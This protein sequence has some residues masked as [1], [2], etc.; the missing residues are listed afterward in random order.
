MAY[1]RKAMLPV[2]YARPATRRRLFGPIRRVTY[3]RS[4]V[5]TVRGAF[6]KRVKAV[7]NTTLEKKFFYKIADVGPFSIA[8]TITAICDVAQGIT[9]VTRIGEKIRCSSIELN[10]PYINGTAFTTWVRTTVLKVT[11]T[12]L[13]NLTSASKIYINQLTNDQDTS[14]GVGLA[15]GNYQLFM[16]KFDPAAVTV[17]WDNYMKLAKNTETSGASVRMCQKYVSLKN[18][19]IDF[20]GATGGSLLQHPRYFLLQTSYTPEVGS[21]S[22]LINKGWTKLRFTDA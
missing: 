14:G 18:T 12:E 2:R 20:D 19:P 4:A 7:I 5:R 17:L 6:A 21:S 22:V 16:A 15:L 1:K 3:K 8:P 13:T 9:D 10:F 11:K